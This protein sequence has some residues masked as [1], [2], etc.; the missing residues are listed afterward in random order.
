MGEGESLVKVVVDAHDHRIIGSSIVGS[1]AAMLL[2]PI[3]WLMN[4]GDGTFLPMA[5]G[6]TIHPALPEVVVEAFGNLRSAGE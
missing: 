3:V 1:H 5:R 4:A 6:Q 2:Q